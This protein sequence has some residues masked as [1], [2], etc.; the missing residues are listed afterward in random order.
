[1]K[2]FR[3][4]KLSDHADIIEAYFTTEVNTNMTS[5]QGEASTTVDLIPGGSYVRV[6]D[7]NK[8]NFI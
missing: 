1:L 3:D 4:N 5:G 6:T 8:Q 7:L 2:F